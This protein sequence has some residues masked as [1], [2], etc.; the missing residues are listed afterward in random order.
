MYFF[1]DAAEACVDLLDRC[2]DSDETDIHLVQLFP[3]AA[4]LGAQGAQLRTNPLQEV[5]E[6]AEEPDSEHADDR[7]NHSGIHRSSSE[8]CLDMRHKL[9]RYFCL[10]QLNFTSFN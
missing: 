10:I 6:H 3:Q 2:L 8:R 7:S 5:A 1:F 9:L 4:D